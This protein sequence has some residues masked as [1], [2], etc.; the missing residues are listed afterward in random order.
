MNASDLCSLLSSSLVIYGLTT[1]PAYPDSLTR[2][3]MSYQT[4]LFGPVPMGQTGIVLLAVFGEDLVFYV[5]LCSKSQSNTQ[6]KHKEQHWNVS[7]TDVVV[8]A[9]QRLSD[10]PAVVM[11]DIGGKG[12]GGVGG[13]SAERL[14]LHGRLVTLRSYLVHWLKI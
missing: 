3:S 5:D 12:L 8:Q 14:A 11:P 4:W 7:G 13:C 1:H 2:N 6:N 10:K 9:A